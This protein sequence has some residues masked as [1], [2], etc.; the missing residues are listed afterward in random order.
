[1]LLDVLHGGADG[2]NASVDAGAGADAHVQ[3]QCN[4]PAAHSGHMDNLGWAHAM[5]AYHSARC[6]DHTRVLMYHVVDHKAE[7]T[8]G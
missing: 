1:M 3:S 8:L 6:R 7:R 5:L 4:W 2:A